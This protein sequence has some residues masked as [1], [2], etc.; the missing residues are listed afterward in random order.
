MQKKKGRKPYQPKDKMLGGVLAHMRKVAYVDSIVH[1][2]RTVT[3][4]EKM[5]NDA[6]MLADAEAKRERKKEKARALC[7]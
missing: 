5:R 1:V 6:E 3:R 7:K 4:S 2:F